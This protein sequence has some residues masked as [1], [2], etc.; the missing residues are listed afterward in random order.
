MHAA[1]DTE[2]VGD[3]AHVRE[4]LADF[5]AALAILFERVRRGE[6]GTGFA[7]GAEVLG[8]ELLACVFFEAGLGSNVSTCE[9]RR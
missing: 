1:D 6:G 3:L 4:D 7:L 9:G 5:E 8:G 2:F